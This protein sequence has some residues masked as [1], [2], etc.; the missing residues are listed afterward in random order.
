[1]KKSWVG[2]SSQVNFTDY[3]TEKK[4]LIVQYRT[5]TYKY[6]NVPPELNLLQTESD[7]VGKFL[8]EKIKPIYAVTKIS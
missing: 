4:E 6:L 8:N 7:S 1:M 3:N 2:K 5:G